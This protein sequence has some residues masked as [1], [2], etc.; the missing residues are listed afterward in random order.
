LV[1]ASL[2]LLG[3]H[4]YNSYLIRF[5]KIELCVLSMKNYG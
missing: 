3:S 2:G 1:H 4:L 5:G